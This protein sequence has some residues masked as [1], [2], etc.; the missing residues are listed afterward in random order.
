MYF[1]SSLDGVLSFLL[2]IF[3]VIQRLCGWRVVWVGVSECFGKVTGL[4]SY[5]SHTAL[6]SEDNCNS[7]KKYFVLPHGE[8]HCCTSLTA[9]VR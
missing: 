6:Q 1:F 5:F 3:V 2:L 8:L 9:S 7:E 4:H